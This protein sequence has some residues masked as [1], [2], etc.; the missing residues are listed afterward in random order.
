ME[1]RISEELLTWLT[2]IVSFDGEGLRV[3]DTEFDVLISID[4]AKIIIENF[5]RRNMVISTTIIDCV[6]VVSK[7]S[8]YD[9]L[10]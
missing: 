6:G 5:G 9:K 2:L 7:N 4:D 1:L 3:I 10:V 8:I